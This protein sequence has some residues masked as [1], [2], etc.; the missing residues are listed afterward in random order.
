MNMERTEITQLDEIL[1]TKISRGQFLDLFR[2]SGRIAADAYMVVGGV[3]YVLEVDAQQDSL[4]CAVELA[5]GSGFV[6]EALTDIQMTLRKMKYIL[7][8]EEE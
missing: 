2:H 8:S 6:A 3:N 1:Q 7:Q 5:Y 4:N